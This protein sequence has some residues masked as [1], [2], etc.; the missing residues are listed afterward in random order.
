MNPKYLKIT[1]Y[2]VGNTLLFI[3]EEQGELWYH[4]KGFKC[5]KQKVEF[6]D[7]GYACIEQHPS[8]T[9]WL[10]VGLRGDSRYNDFR[11]EAVKSDDLL[12]MQKRVLAA[13]EV[14]AQHIATIS[15]SAPTTHSPIVKEFNA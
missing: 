14:A 1:S 12:N 15:D 7:K 6:T 9:G 2:I 3:V 10:R 8:K 4:L 5:P 11:I 13:L